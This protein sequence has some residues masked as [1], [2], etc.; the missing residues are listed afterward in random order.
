VIQGLTSF[1]M[2][3]STLS[4]PFSSRS[5]PSDLCGRPKR[6]RACFIVKIVYVALAVL[7]LVLKNRLASN[8]QRSPCLCLLSAG[9]KSMNHHLPATACSLFCMLCLWWPPEQLCSKSP[10]CPDGSSASSCQ[11]CFYLHFIFLR[12]SFFFFFFFLKRFI[13]YM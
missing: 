1:H 12:Q 8:S 13:Y 5:P 3:I 4:Q 6:H 2:L 10:S 9:I 7:E 11:V